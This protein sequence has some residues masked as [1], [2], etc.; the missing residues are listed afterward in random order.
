LAFAKAV[1]N[2]FPE[3]GLCVGEGNWSMVKVLK[4]SFFLIMIL[5][6]SNS[7]REAIANQSSG[8][9]KP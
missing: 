1:R 7:V 8:G 9:S 4:R 6:G 5:M 3:R 2:M